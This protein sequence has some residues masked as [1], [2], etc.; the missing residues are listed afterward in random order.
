LFP[1]RV[2]FWKVIRPLLPPPFERTL[3]TPSVPADVEGA[4][5]PV[6]VQ[7]RMVTV[8]LGAVKSEMAA[9]K[10]SALLFEKVDPVTVSEPWGMRMKI[11]PPLVEP[12]LP[13]NVESVTVRCQP[14]TTA[15]GLSSRPR[16]PPNPLLVLER[17]LQRVMLTVPRVATAF[18]GAPMAPP[19]PV[20]LF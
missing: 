4:V 13:S 8:S 16:P 19:V 2:Q 9:P 3:P 1:D 10:L 5:L 18:P 14:F 20:L 7:L 6:N 11:P 17:N 15:P 12:V